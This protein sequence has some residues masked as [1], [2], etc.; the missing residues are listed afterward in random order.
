MK[1]KYLLMGAALFSPLG[2][3]ANTINTDHINFPQIQEAFPLAAQ[4]HGSGS[5]LKMENGVR[6]YG[7]QHKTGKAN[8]GHLHFAKADV[9]E[10]KCFPMKETKGETCQ[11][12]KITL[13]S[14]SLGSFN[15]P[16]LPKKQAKTA[17][18]SGQTEIAG[19]EHWLSSYSINS[20]TV[21]VKVGEGDAYIYV[22][23]K[24]DINNA[25][26]GTPEQKV[27]IV[28]YSGFE[29][30]N[31]ATMYGSL[32]TTGKV[33]VNG[34]SH[35]KLD[36]SL[37]TGHIDANNRVTIEL[38]GGNHWFDSMELNGEM[39]LSLL[40]S[41]AAVFHIKNGLIVN[42][43]TVL[44]K[45]VSEETASS[46]LLIHYGK[47]EI[48]INNDVT[49]YNYLYSAGSIEMNGR[50]DIYG[51][52]ST[53]KLHMN[54]EAT[55]NYRPMFFETE[56]YPPTFYY[57][58]DYGQTSHELMA[59][60]CVNS[61]CSQVYSED[62]QKLNIENKL[63]SSILAKFKKFNGKSDEVFNI[64]KNLDDSK[65][66]QFGIE[67]ET[68]EGGASPWPTAT[69]PLQC[70][71]D[72][73]RIADCYVC[74]DPVDLFGYVY[75]DAF[76]P[77]LSPN[78]E[79]VFEIVDYKADGDGIFKNSQTGEVFKEG[80]KLTNLPMLV[81]YDKPGKVTLT[82]QQENTARL[83]QVVITFVPKY[84]KWVDKDEVHNVDAAS[85]DF[86]TECIDD[87][88]NGYVYDTKRDTCAVLGKVGDAVALTLQVYGEEDN[89]GKMQII[90]NY[91]ANLANI[92][93]IEELSAAQ[94][95]QATEKAE[96]S[97]SYFKAVDGNGST[98]LYKPEHVALI[99]ATVGNH[100]AVFG[101]NDAGECPRITLGEENV[102]VGRTVPHHLDVNETIAGI[103]D[104]NVAYR[105]KA[106]D[107]SVPPSFEISACGNTVSKDLADH[108][109]KTEAEAVAGDEVATAAA[110]SAA[111]AA[112]EQKMDS[113]IAEQACAL[114]PSYSGEFAAG[115][116]KH[117]TVKP[118]PELAELG[119][120]A[121]T[122]A[123]EVTEK[124]DTPGIHTVGLTLGDLVPEKV[125]PVAETQFEGTLDL[126]VTE[127][128]TLAGLLG[129]TKFANDEAKL[130]FGYFAMEDVE[131]PFN[132]EGRMG[133]KFMYHDSENKA[134]PAA[135]DHFNFKNDIRAKGV[136]EEI[137]VISPLNSVKPQSEMQDLG[138][139]F[140]KYSSSA[141]D[142][143]GKTQ[144][145][146]DVTLPSAAVWLKPYHVDSGLV[147]PKARLTIGD[148]K[149]GN[150]RVFNRRE[151]LQ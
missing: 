59:S 129:E 30:N 60:A 130:R 87:T 79:D 75:G 22:D 135:A 3:Q 46:L 20:T 6:I 146:F 145:E 12:T 122:L 43:G 121:A 117:T 65:C 11:V 126:T 27:H 83:R 105:G 128:D 147:P 144:R 36:G 85:I 9:D 19:G 26:L 106:I 7:T 89:Q 66:V 132:T 93:K 136:T 92:V 15:P 107:F 84:L 98:V 76:I 119:L 82:L 68:T 25:T 72:G 112:A 2:L 71:V 58:L 38:G 34:G 16:P 37:R 73:I 57:R 109:V 116:A 124:K 63:S 14:H 110:N 86:S 101:Y 140:S 114:L 51:A 47:S 50:S 100:C 104:K 29:I 10:G 91:E 21:T 23:G 148:L 143:N 142:G 56:T 127:H 99:R 24:V 13:P 4:G 8:A 118:S 49:M 61:D 32:N 39:K 41:V 96:L 131:L 151:A 113:A 53:T 31:K 150:D 138:V 115:L 139:F 134:Q 111:R 44:N 64:A 133:G 88:A 80:D 77:K 70:Y 33:V 102:I 95:N 18:I 5:M 123:I 48:D 40:P 42:G 55:I 97:N 28:S 141:N 69:P 35:L 54:G 108:I 74:E 62:V 90:N 120:T 45:P 67:D 78:A 17:A 1:I 52:V 81:T 125:A 149:R 103:V 94:K 137:T